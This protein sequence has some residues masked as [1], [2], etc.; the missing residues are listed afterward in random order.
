[1][2]SETQSKKVRHP[3]L[4]ISIFCVLLSFSLVAIAGLG[5][6]LSA[7]NDAIATLQNDLKEVN[8]AVSVLD[9]EQKTAQSEI[10][11]LESALAT[12]DR[13][14][15][16][17]TAECE[18]LK[19]EL[20]QALAERKQLM[21][22]LEQSVTEQ[23]SMKKRLNALE[24]AGQ[25]AADEI[26]RLKSELESVKKEIANLKNQVSSPTDKI[27]IY[28]DQGHNPVPYHNSG[29]SGNGLQEDEVTFLI[30]SLLAEL[31]RN[32]YRFEVQLSRPNKSVVL[33]TD[34]ASS[35]MARVRGAATFNADYLISLHTNAFTSESANGIEVYSATETSESY[36]F[37]QTLLNG[38]LTSTNLRNRG[39]KLN[40]DLDILEFSAMPAVLVEMGFISNSGDATLMAEHPELF[41]QGLYNGILSYF[42][43]LPV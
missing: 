38:L 17:L 12:T 36:V 8:E 29:S 18:Q 23:D 2:T 33:G 27:R 9:A 43:F 11:A 41:A 30:G 22:D 24:T 14:V 25:S 3:R 7:S 13:E 6:A 35:L 19:A 40:P 34:N 39:M 32:D 21:A 16:D 31:L 26:A 42:G 10:D 15:E 20:Q 37:G 28:I 1:M 5:T 4:W